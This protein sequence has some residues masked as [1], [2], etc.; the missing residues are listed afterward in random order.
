MNWSSIN[1]FLNIVLIVLVIGY[2]INYFYRLPKYE[3]GEKA[4][5]FTSTLLS[6]DT[7]TLSQLRG[8]YVLLDFW[9]SWCG[10]CRRESP[11]LVSLYN[12]MKEQ[13]FKAAGSFHIVSIGIETKRENWENAIQK[14]GLIWP[15]HIGEMDRF[16][17]KIAKLYGVR[18]IPTKY[19]INP[20]GVILS[21]NEDISEIRSYLLEQTEK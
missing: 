5:D 8:S 14:D 9:G 13:K 20:E 1:K 17:G 10:P 15:Y 6:G 7:F 4:L 11:D 21:V 16:S 18:E 3:S 19:L 12:E 2:I